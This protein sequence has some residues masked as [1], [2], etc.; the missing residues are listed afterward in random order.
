MYL[1]YYWFSV[2]Q[3]LQCS[4]WL[5]ISWFCTMLNL[6]QFMLFPVRML[7]Y[8]YMFE[9]YSF[10]CVVWHVL[11]LNLECKHDHPFVAHREDP[12]SPGEAG[13][14]KNRCC[15]ACKS[16]RQTS[17]CAVH[18]VCISQKIINTAHNYHSHYLHHFV[19]YVNCLYKWSND[20]SLTCGIALCFLLSYRMLFKRL[21]NELLKYLENWESSYCCRATTCLYF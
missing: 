14:S 18:Q 11:F 12:Y 4:W 17:S 5:L 6:H 9:K 13:V 10:S 7:S 3:S 8:Y 19:S 20:V 16:R 1:R 2:D 15:H 21:L